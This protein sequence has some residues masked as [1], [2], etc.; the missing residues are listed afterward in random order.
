MARSDHRRDA[1]RPSFAVVESAGQWV[2]LLWF[3]LL[4]ASSES[5]VEICRRNTASSVLLMSVSPWA[6][7]QKT[8]RDGQ[9]RSRSTAS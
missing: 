2:V 3:Q 7:N 1:V 4:V 9:E 6:G 5:M 8:E